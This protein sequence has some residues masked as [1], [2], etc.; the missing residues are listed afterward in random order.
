MFR[1]K[2]PQSGLFEAG[3]MMPASKR[4]RLERSWAETFRRKALP[5]IDE[6]QFAPL[7]CTDNGRPNQPVQ[8][9]FGVLLLKEMFGLTDME[10]LEQLEFSLLWHHALAVSSDEAHLC[11]KTLHNFRARLLARDKGRSAFEATTAR[12]L[13]AL[14]T[15]VVRQRMDS[16]Q[17]TSNMASLSR[18]GLFCETIRH[19]LKQLRAAR[20]DLYAGVSE[21]LRDRYLKR[22]GG[23]TSYEDARSSACVRRLSVCARDLYRLREQ[24]SGTAA[25]SLDAYGL[26]DRLLSEQCE[27][28]SEERAPSGEDDDA[29]EGGVPVAL[30]AAGRI[31]GASLQSPHDPDATYS[32]RK[33]KGYAVQLVETCAGGDAV[34]ADEAV[35]ADPARPRPVNVITHVEVADAC[36]SDEHATIPALE[37]LDARGQ[38]PDELIADTAYGSGANALEAAGMDTLVIAPVKGPKAVAEKEPG[39]IDQTDFEIDARPGGQVRCPAGQ[40]PVIRAPRERNPR[41]LVLT[42]AREVCAACDLLARCPVKPDRKTGSC[43]VTVDRLASHLARRRRDME[44]DAFRDRY[45]LRAGIEG[46]ISELKRRH[47]LGALRVRGRPRVELAV[48]LKTLACNLKRMVWAFAPENE[49]MRLKIP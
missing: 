7:Y 2:S 19:F 44:T 39:A 22:D 36:A 34:E 6:G 45:R 43:V 33:G 20:P 37:A 3:V 26:I 42:F 38:R 27:G 12:I 23:G 15:K 24:C 13:R 4:R 48:H 11:Q 18:L 17:V 5:L 35:E 10:A 14:G 49:V 31:S 9:V 47:G 28:V 46:T 1:K 29:G 25:A 21:R 32:A 8:T 16:T 40:T 30:K 41:R